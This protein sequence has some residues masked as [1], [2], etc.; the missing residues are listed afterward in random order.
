MIGLYKLKAR[1]LPFVVILLIIMQLIDPSR[2][3]TS[4]LVGFGGAWL[5]AY[6]WARS[7]S[8]NIRMTREMRFGWAQVGDQLEERF[9]LVNSSSL[10]ATWV[11]VSIIP[12]CLIFNL[13]RPVWMERFPANG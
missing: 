6:F 12:R 10:P 8:K 4:L 3:W 5:L 1:L 11:E 2:I 13:H 7:L 9:T